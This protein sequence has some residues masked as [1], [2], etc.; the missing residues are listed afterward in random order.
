LLG[1]GG[2]GKSETD[3]MRPSN[4][5]SNPDLEVGGRSSNERP[6]VVNPWEMYLKYNMIKQ[7][8]ILFVCLLLE[9]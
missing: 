2:E 7:I 9:F 3:N 4:E 5:P 6:E 1:S 8:Y